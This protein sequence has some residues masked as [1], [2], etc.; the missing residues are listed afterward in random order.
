VLLREFRAAAL[1]AGRYELI[2]NPAGQGGGRLQ[3]VRPAQEIFVRL[4]EEAGATFDRMAMYAQGGV[5][6]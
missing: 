3:A 6:G 2:N 4:V 1:A 5:R